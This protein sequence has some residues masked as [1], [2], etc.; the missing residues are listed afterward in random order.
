MSLDLLLSTE[1]FDIAIMQLRFLGLVP[2][3][4]GA[5]MAMPSFPVQSLTEHDSGMSD[6]KDGSYSGKYQDQQGSFVTSFEPPPWP[7]F[8]TRG[9]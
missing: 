9:H 8:K 2:L 1:F 5:A 4:L 7:S 3:L 6:C